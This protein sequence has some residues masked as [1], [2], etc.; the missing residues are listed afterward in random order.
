[1]MS[2]IDSLENMNISKFKIR[3][4]I[5]DNKKGQLLKDQG[6]DDKQLTISYCK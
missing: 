6:L 5:K 4:G 3:N 1:M 2:Y